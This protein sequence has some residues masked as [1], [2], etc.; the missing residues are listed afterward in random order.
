MLYN[1]SIQKMDM[2]VCA[3]PKNLTPTS[4]YCAHV[5]INRDRYVMT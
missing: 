1:N 2:L 5:T 4:A 3:C